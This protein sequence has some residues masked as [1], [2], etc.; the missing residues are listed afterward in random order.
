MIWG[1]S[2]GTTNVCVL[3]AS[4]ELHV[5]L[6]VAGEEDGDNDDDELSV[7]TSPVVSNVDCFFYKI[8]FK[9]S[10]RKPKIKINGS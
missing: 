7:F 2:L 1:G 9:Y 10:Q 4:N 3:E 6:I 8:K 5:V